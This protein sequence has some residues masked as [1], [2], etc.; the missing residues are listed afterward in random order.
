MGKL[1]GT[2]GVR[3]V[4]NTE[5]TPE[6][7]FNLGRA[8]ASI[9]GEEGLP[10]IEVMPTGT[11]VMGRDTRASGDMLEGALIAGICSVGLSVLK[12]GVVP[13]PAVAYLARDLR[14]SAGIM[15]SASHNPIE[16][17]GIKFFSAD[18]FKIPDEVE[19]QI[20]TLIFGRKDPLPR[21]TGEKIGRVIPIEEAEDRYLDHIKKTV[22]LSLAG[23]RIVVD[24]AHG[25]AYRIAPRLLREL[26][27]EVI[28][29]NTQP[30]GININVDCG[31][32]HPERLQKT[33]LK[34]KAH[35][36]LAFDGDA[37]RVLGVDEK[38]RLVDGDQIMAILVESLLR[39][40]ALRQKIL[41]TTVMSNFGL[42]QTMK[43]FDV[44]VV[45]TK[46]GDRHVLQEMRRTKAQIGGEQSGHVILLDHNTTGDGI[47]TSLHLLE[48]LKENGKPLSEMANL[49]EPLPQLLVNV[50]VKDKT[51]FQEDEEIQEAIK[52][53]EAM[54]EQKGRVMVRPSGTEPLIRVMAEGMDKD[55]VQR[56]VEALASVIDKKLN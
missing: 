18:G 41:V 39:Q 6:M 52:E 47:L 24:G 53:M 30:N 43:R 27:A 44:K 15:I 2:D 4:A 32:T 3:G 25:A 33:V 12:V 28:S 16:D 23:Y 13:T 20:E 22:N 11:I 45:R 8:A 38:G 34:E 55:A 21:P 49:V 10:G 54:L 14:A 51:R 50:P 36:G 17:N 48:S 19:E 29:L 40:G 1:F 7:A 35:L 5:L 42:E 56:V 9:L 26:G 31:S 46:V 37:D